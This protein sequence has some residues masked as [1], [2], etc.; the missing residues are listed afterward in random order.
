MVIDWIDGG[1]GAGLVWFV[2]IPG[3]TQ[4]DDHDSMIEQITYLIDDRNFP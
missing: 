2:D 1:F 4:F 3:Y